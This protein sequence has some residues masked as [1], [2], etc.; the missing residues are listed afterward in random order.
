[1][2]A[3]NYSVTFTESGLPSGTSWYVSLNG[4]A[5]YSTSTTIVLML[6]NGD[7]TYTVKPMVTV[8]SGTEYEASPSEGN[9]TVAG[10]ALSEPVVYGAM[11]YLTVS[12]SPAGAGTVSQASGW[13]SSGAKV[14]LQ[15]VPSSGYYF[16]GWTGSSSPGYSG[17]N[18]P[19]SLTMTAPI[20]EEAVFDTSPCW[21]AGSVS[22]TGATL[23]IDGISIT[24]ATNGTFNATVASGTHSI[25]VSDTGYQTQSFNVSLKA[26][27]GVKEVIALKPV[28]NG[29]NTGTSQLFGGGFPLLL[30]VIVAIIAV[31]LLVFV[32]AWRRRE[33]K[34]GPGNTVQVSQVSNEEPSLNQPESD[35][36]PDVA[37]AAVAYYTA[38]GAQA[39]ETPSDPNEPL[40]E[41]SEDDA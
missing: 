22:P 8:G 41:Y 38:P 39:P 25:V 3:Q 29:G 21:I 30:I 34:K 19:A 11:F 28:T 10:T 18:N 13:I 32:V 14:S 26:G 2:V 31:A 40:P 1:M 9:L 7:Y 37:P 12:I 36:G 5:T 24:I 27:T 6:V 20:S 17:P 35:L 33:N 23:L 4:T 15:A 16:V